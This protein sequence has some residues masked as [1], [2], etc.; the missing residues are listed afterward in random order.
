M[1]PNVQLL[2]TKLHGN[3]ATSWG[4]FQ[5]EDSN[6]EYLIIKEAS[7]NITTTKVS[8]ANSWLGTSPD[9]TVHDPTTNPPN[10]LV[11]FPKQ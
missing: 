1:G 5:E 7:P 3:V 4:N 9:Q 8:I 11:E 6:R 10:D 2:H